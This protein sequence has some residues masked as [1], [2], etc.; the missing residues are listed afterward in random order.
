APLAHAAADRPVALGDLL[1]DEAGVAA[2]ARLR[3]GTVPGD[4]LAV[5]IPVA[6]VEELP[7]AR[8]AF[9]ELAL[10]TAEDAAH[11]GRHRLMER[12]HVPALRIARAAEELPVAAE[13][14]LHRAAA[15]LAHLVRRLGLGGADRA[16]LVAGEVLRVLALGIA[17]AGEELAPPAPFDHHRLAALLAGEAGRA[18]LR[19]PV[20]HLDLG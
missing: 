1:G 15:L 10:A 12:L 3:D 9:H 6:A 16:V 8:A 20:T 13:A 2:R 17:R 5:G 19:L 18:L 7:A 11:A 14:D 4:E